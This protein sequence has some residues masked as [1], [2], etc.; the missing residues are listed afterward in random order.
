MKHKEP[1]EQP[2]SLVTAE[3]QANATMLAMILTRKMPGFDRDSTKASSSP[4]TLP[5][6]SLSS[7]I[8]YLST[9]T[10]ACASFIDDPAQD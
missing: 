2:P 1:E 6:V 3:S 4:I 8:Q 9:S 7:T 10:V 5:S